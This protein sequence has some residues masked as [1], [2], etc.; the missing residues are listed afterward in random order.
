MGNK[1]WVLCNYLSV[2]LEGEL[3]ESYFNVVKGLMYFV[4]ESV[5]YLLFIVFE[6]V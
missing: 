4:I 6:E 5:W 1:L 2:F 3:R